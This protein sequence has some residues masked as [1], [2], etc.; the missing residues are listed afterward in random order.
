[1]KS[2]KKK[3]INPRA[4]E[5]LPDFLVML[6]DLEFER[7]ELYNAPFLERSGKHLG[8]NYLIKCA[9]DF[10][11]L[12]VW[13]GDVSPEILFGDA[14]GKYTNYQYST[15]V[16][17]GGFDGLVGTL[18]PF[19]GYEVHIEN[20]EQATWANTWS[21]RHTDLPEIS[22]AVSPAWQSELRY[23]DSELSLYTQGSIFPLALLPPSS[24]APLMV[25]LWDITSGK[26]QD[27]FLYFAKIYNKSLLWNLYGSRE[28][29]V[30][31][32]NSGAV[33]N[34]AWWVPNFLY[35]EA[36]NGLLVTGWYYGQ[37][38]GSW[39]GKE[40]PEPLTPGEPAS[41]G[42]V[43]FNA[44]LDSRKQGGG[45]LPYGYAEQLVSLD[46]EIFN[47]VYL[48]LS[49]SPM[50]DYGNPSYLYQ[51]LTQNRDA[52]TEMHGKAWTAEFRPD[53]PPP[54]GTG[55]RYEPYNVSI[56]NCA[57]NRPDRILPYEQDYVGVVISSGQDAMV[58]L[59]TGVT[60]TLLDTDE[61]HSHSYSSNGEILAV[62]LG[63]G[64][65]IT[66]CVVFDLRNVG[67]ILRDT[68]NAET[69]ADSIDQL[70]ADTAIVIPTYGE[71]YT[72]G[73]PSVPVDA[74]G[75]PVTSYPEL[76]FNEE[77]IVK[78]LAPFGSVQYNNQVVR[79]YHWKKVVIEDGIYASVKDTDDS[80]M[81]GSL[82][83][84]RPDNFP[85]VGNY[86][87]T[88]DGVEYTGTWGQVSSLLPYTLFSA[89]GFPYE[90]ALCHWE[91]GP[92]GDPIGVAI[93]ATIDRGSVYNHS[94]PQPFIVYDVSLGRYV[95]ESGL[96]GDE[97]VTEY[98]DPINDPCGGYSYTVASGV[99][100]CGQTAEYVLS[101]PPFAG[102]PG[103]SGD[104]TEVDVGWV[105]T[106]TGGLPPYQNWSFGAGTLTISGVN[107]QTAT[108]ATIT[109]CAAPGDSAYGDIYV[110]DSCGNAAQ[111]SVSLVGADWCCT[112]E[113]GYWYGYYC[114]C[115][116]GTPKCCSGLYCCNT[117][118]SWGYTGCK[119]KPPYSPYTTNYTGDIGGFS[120][121]EHWQGC[122][123]AIGDP[124]PP[125]CCEG[126]TTGY[127][128]GTDKSAWAASVG[129]QVACHTQ[130]KRI[131]AV[132][133]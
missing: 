72:P 38:G 112:D 36:G 86:T 120:Y 61:Y 55:G 133:P 40:D 59:W 100:S 83:I 31:S 48:Y 52:G 27:N 104:R 123:D 121:Y 50:W 43:V 24:Y 93:D 37:L 92:S 45:I 4:E 101:V 22:G 68:T 41:T 39:V 18:H 56:W 132:C 49:G 115:P 51:G 6:R 10:D 114:P 5:L 81:N 128:S 89:G 96:G 106:A 12:I 9:I 25:D 35:A 73:S 23:F 131:E 69:G 79:G 30:Y 78:A 124:D 34:S 20:R 17:G 29:W 88:V 21:S 122:I 85:P 111:I 63:S 57:D 16:L 110:E 108:I 11:K 66:R 32:P 99:N 118:F 119:P 71:G 65:L 70:L 3:F 13:G 113:D 19:V 47:R 76:L 87:I 98:D 103:I 129:A 14:N 94:V 54:I 80:C 67:V 105:Y 109:G 107:N 82:T 75:T 44:L 8:Y 26:A 117:W 28:W 15:D 84:I 90:V 60:Y 2:L 127:V 130:V 95:M 62:F 116:P 7:K 1:V 102:G 64:S 46:D 53:F 77:E 91:I 33:F 97:E 58:R 42:E 74:S 126:G 125:E